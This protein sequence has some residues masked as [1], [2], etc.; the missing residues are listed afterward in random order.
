MKYFRPVAEDTRD[1]VAHNNMDLNS[2]IDYFY[3]HY[4]DTSAQ[5]R[6]QFNH[7]FVR[8]HTH[9]D[10]VEFGTHY[11]MCAYDHSQ[12]SEDM[13][14]SFD[15]NH[16]CDTQLHEQYQRYWDWVQGCRMFAF[17]RLK[18]SA[19]L[20]MT[21]QERKRLAAS[22]VKPS[23]SENPLARTRLQAMLDSLKQAAPGNCDNIEEAYKLIHNTRN[24]Y[25][26]FKREYA[27]GR[28]QEIAS[29]YQLHHFIQHAC[30]IM[31]RQ[32]QTSSGY[33]DVWAIMKTCI[34][35]IDTQNIDV[36]EFPIKITNRRHFLYVLRHSWPRVVK[37]HQRR[38]HDNCEEFKTFISTLDA[39]ALDDFYDGIY[40]GDGDCFNLE[41]ISAHC[42]WLNEQFASTMDMHSRFKSIPRE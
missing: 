26:E 32:H 41:Q 2:M 33:S 35:R 12:S 39:A 18:N 6:E 31:V 22:W 16:Y 23:S 15:P 42:D 30:S 40:D 28:P 29:D 21:A 14:Y 7:W 34:W 20:P 8:K 27:T 17:A 36:L 3:D 24:W 1:L 13:I 9:S 19:L 37:W 38:L 11:N 4:A 25:Q 10:I 5:P